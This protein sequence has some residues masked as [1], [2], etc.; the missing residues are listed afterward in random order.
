[1]PWQ[2]CSTMSLRQEFLALASQPGNNFSHAIPCV[3]FPVRQFPDLARS[4]DNG[5][6]FF[7][8]SF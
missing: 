7:V 4:T 6:S 2:E 1:M 3:A 8:R 5:S